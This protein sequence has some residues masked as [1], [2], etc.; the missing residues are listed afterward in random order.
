MDG[1]ILD[2]PVGRTI[3]PGHSI[4]NAWFLM[5]YANLTDDKELLQKALNIFKMVLRNRLG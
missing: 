2:N 5:N 1:S 4:E 3:N